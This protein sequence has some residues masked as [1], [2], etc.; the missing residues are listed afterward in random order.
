MMSAMGM[1]DGMSTV[2]GKNG[3]GIIATFGLC[4]GKDC[5]E[6]T[7]ITVVLVTSVVWSKNILDYVG[8]EDAHLWFARAEQ[9]SIY[10]E[11][12]GLVLDTIEGERIFICDIDRDEAI[13]HL[14]YAKT[15]SVDLLSYANKTIV[16]PDEDECKRMMTTD[17]SLMPM[18]DFD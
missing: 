6:V 7:D 18:I 12:P 4:D 9:S 16:N 17:F 15:G 5:K 3:Y 8:E 2:L 11:I 10:R 1:L 13:I 14:R